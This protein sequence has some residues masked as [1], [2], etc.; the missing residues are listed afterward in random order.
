MRPTTLK[1]DIDIL[2]VTLAENPD[3]L[4][5][6]KA[7]ALAEDKRSDNYKRVYTHKNHK[8]KVAKFKELQ[9]K[10]PKVKTK[11]YKVG[12]QVTFEHGLS[13][14]VIYTGIIT[15][16]D[17]EPR[18]Y[19]ITVEGYPATIILGHHELLKKEVI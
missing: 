6:W 3:D 2:A 14:K 13:Q 11:I 12:Q 8:P 7:M 16:K 5:I 4:D 9:K 10:A 18:Q 19:H 1:D 15:R 17:A